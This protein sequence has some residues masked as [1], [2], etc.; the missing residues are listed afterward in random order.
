MCCFQ[1]S[2]PIYFYETFKFSTT[3]YWFYRKWIHN[4]GKTSNLIYFNK[5]QQSD[6]FS[7]SYDDASN[8]KDLSSHFGLQTY[9]RKV[10]TFLRSRI[11]VFVQVKVS[12]LSRIINYPIL[13]FVCIP[14][15]FLV[16][17]QSANVL[18]SPD[19]GIEGC[20]EEILFSQ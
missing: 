20:L 11:K 10:Y 3:F 6:Y 4:S 15:L 13:M 2:E 7:I 17:T 19:F 14:L 18:F 12:N 1:W 8:V 5:K 9:T 16:G